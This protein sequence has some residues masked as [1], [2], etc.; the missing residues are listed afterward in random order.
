MK[1]NNEIKIFPNPAI[2]FEF[3]VND[4]IQRANSTVDTKGLFSVVLA[5][6]KDVATYSCT[7]QLLTLHSNPPTTLALPELTSLFSLPSSG[8][9]ESIIGITPT[10]SIIHIF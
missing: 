5:G 9:H 1:K 4:F 2:L 10:F 6:G 7:D 3:A 8:T